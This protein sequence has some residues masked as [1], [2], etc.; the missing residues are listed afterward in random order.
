[1]SDQSRDEGQGRTPSVVGA[2]GR[3]R[4]HRPGSADPAG[5]LA[6]ATGQLGWRPGG[7]VGAAAGGATGGAALG[8]VGGAIAGDTGS[9]PSR[10]SWD[11]TYQ[12]PIAGLVFNW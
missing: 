7:T 9:G 3:L 4:S 5:R 6:A 10:F 8:A 1:M 11:V 12:G 2:A